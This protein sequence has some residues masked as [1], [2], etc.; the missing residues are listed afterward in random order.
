MSLSAQGPSSPRPRLHVLDFI[1]LVAMLLMIQGHTLDAFVNPAHM[2]LDSFHW[3][4]WVHLRGLTAPLFLMVSGAASVLGIRYEQDGRIARSLLRRR[5]TT[6][7]VVI[8]IGY[9]MVFPANRIA[10]LWWVSAE[11]WQ[12]CLQVN[13]LQLNGITLLL[14]TT[15]LAC[16]RTVRR[17]AAWSLGLG[18]LVLLLAPIVFSID[19]FRW[20]PEGLAAYLSFGHGSLF[21]L[22]PASAYMFLGVG[23]GAL[24]VET[25]EAKRVRV[26]RLACLTASAALMLLSLAAERLPADLF[27]VHDAYKAGHVYTLLRVGFALLIFGLLAWIA[28]VFPRLAAGC[29]PMGRKSLYVYV[30]HLVLIYG[31]PWTPGIVTGRFHALSVGDGTVFIPLV[32][33]ITFGAILAWDWLRNRSE[34]VRTFVHASAVFVLAYALV[35]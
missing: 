21:P 7:L 34:A 23:L 8:A 32:G 12:G 35:F 28:E 25:P 3:Q 29:A 24:L 18:F 20:L 33:G 22:F 30:G 2:D 26:F 27:P 4:T 11:V 1:R 14:L 9:L 17:Y 6:G 31:T 16:T 5:F 10:D 19:W 13:I 15:L